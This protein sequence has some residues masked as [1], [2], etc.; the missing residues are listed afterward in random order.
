VWK[1]TNFGMSTLTAGYLVSTSE[2]RGTDEYTAPEI[3]HAKPGIPAYFLP[4]D[5]YA[6]GLILY[7]S[8]TGHRVFYSRAEALAVPPLTPRLFPVSVAPGMAASAAVLASSVITRV[9]SAPGE[10]GD[11]VREFWEAVRGMALTDRR[12]Y[13]GYDAGTAERIEEINGFLRVM[14][15][16]DP[17]KRPR[18]DVLEHHFHANLLRC[19]MESDAVFSPVS[20]S[21]GY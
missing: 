21:V 1:L 13:R 7:E 4:V 10:S 17:L 6:L 12:I 19:L 15:E 11:L 18:M 14:L 5:V 20:F 8:F 2:N 16:V 9:L 3:L